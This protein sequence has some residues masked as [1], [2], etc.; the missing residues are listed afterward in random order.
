MLEQQMGRNSSRNRYFGKVGPLSSLRIEA[1]FYKHRYKQIL[2]F[3][4]SGA[5][6]YFYMLIYDQQMQLVMLY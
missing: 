2:T 5:S 6:T 1:K 4:P 3:L